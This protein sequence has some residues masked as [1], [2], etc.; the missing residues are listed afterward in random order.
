MHALK[1]RQPGRVQHRA[2]IV[3]ALT[4]IPI[5]IV[6]FLFLVT[7]AGALAAAALG[8]HYTKVDPVD[9]KLFIRNGSARIQGWLEL[10]CGCCRTRDLVTF[11]TLKVVQ[12]HHEYH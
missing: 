10:V 8:L 3:T 6:L 12:A 9:I 5:S 1:R 4:M 11:C 7:L 2:R